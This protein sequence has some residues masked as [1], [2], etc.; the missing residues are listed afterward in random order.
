[1]TISL[2]V[3]IF[4]SLSPLFAIFSRARSF[5]I[6]FSVIMTEH[7]VWMC[8]WM[9]GWNASM[10]MR[11]K[12]RCYIV[13]EQ[14]NA[15]NFPNTAFSAYK[16]KSVKHFY[17]IWFE[18]FLFCFIS[19]KRTRATTSTTFRSTLRYH[20]A[21]PLVVYRYSSCA[22]WF[23]FHNFSLYYFSLFGNDSCQKAH[24]MLL[25]AYKALNKRSR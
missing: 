20:L 13:F 8:L 5:T 24:L 23:Y 10:L 18:Y 17:S 21:F 11:N 12:K 19:S 3:R 15:G 14:K 7:K 2:C 22:I 25:I 4:L 6:A 1:M 16:H 9:R